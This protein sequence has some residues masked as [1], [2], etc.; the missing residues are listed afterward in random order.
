MV[1]SS[2][3]SALQPVVGEQVPFRTIL[4]LIQDKYMIRVTSEKSLNLDDIEASYLDMAGRR[5]EHFC[6]YPLAARKRSTLLI[7][8]PLS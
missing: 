2:A 3:A 8:G 7:C 5:D 1:V 6:L 4:Y